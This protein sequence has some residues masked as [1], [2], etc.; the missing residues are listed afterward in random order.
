MKEQFFQGQLLL[1]DQ[2]V[3]HCRVSYPQLEPG[4]LPGWEK[5]L[6]QQYQLFARGKW[7]RLVATLYP[8]A[9]AS[10]R[11]LAPY[12]SFQPLE[13]NC[14][15][16]VMYCQGDWCSIFFDTY[17]SQGGQMLDCGRKSGTFCAGRGRV[18]LESLFAKG[19]DYRGLLLAQLQEQVARQAARDPAAYYVDWPALLAKKFDCQNFYLADDGLVIF[20]PRRALGPSASGLPAFLVPYSAFGSG[21][22]PEL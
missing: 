14:E 9:C 13:A 16:T 5:H 15:Y 22:L 1:A 21:L 10:Y 11:R 8:R 6:S 4:E 12:H 17:V 20:Y 3:L 19:F 18:G 2:P 7:E